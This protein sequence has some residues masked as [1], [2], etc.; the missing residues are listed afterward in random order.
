[1][2]QATNS[3]KITFPTPNAAWVVPT[4]VAIFDGAGDSANEL[5]RASLGT[6][7]AP[8]AN[9]T[10]E[11]AASALTFTQATSAVLKTEGAE[12]SIMGIFDSTVYVALLRNGTELSGSNYARVSV[13]SN[14]WTI[15]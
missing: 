4:H 8:Q 5:L 12:Q 6:V 3:Q 15:T 13:A 11:F 14:R 7:S 9:D 2:A 10:V 1:M